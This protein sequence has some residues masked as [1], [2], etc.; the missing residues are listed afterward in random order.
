MKILVV[1][2]NQTTNEFITICLLTNQLIN[3]TNKLKHF[4]SFAFAQVSA[5]WWSHEI[6]PDRHGPWGSWGTSEF[7]PH[8]QFATAFELKVSISLMAVCCAL[9]WCAK[10]YHS[11]L[12]VV[13]CF[14][15]VMHVVYMLWYDVIR[16][17]VMWCSVM[18]CDVMWCDVVWYSMLCCVALCCGI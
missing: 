17:D 10:M 7:C 18:C 5:R 3:A 9:L 2:K 11:V 6:E 4:S 8:G 1:R 15:C 13:F 14:V 12:C 16:C